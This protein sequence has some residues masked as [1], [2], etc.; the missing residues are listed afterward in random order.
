MSIR[1]LRTKK[2]Q[3]RPD[4]C[5]PLGGCAPQ[6]PCCFCFSPSFLFSLIIPKTTTFP[7]PSPFVFQLACC[8]LL[9]FCFVAGCVCFRPLRRGLQFG[10]YF[11]GRG[12]YNITILHITYY[13]WHITLLHYYI[14]TLS[15]DHMITLLQYYN[16][17][18]LQYYNT[19][20]RWN[21]IQKHCSQQTNRHEVRK[22]V[23]W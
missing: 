14:I 20:D 17:T 2:K 5:R 23:T 12:Y 10:V 3:Q 19:L 16:I 11:T 18:I 15:H 21:K 6:T 13:I 22:T 4:G 1:L 9:A 8:C 7:P